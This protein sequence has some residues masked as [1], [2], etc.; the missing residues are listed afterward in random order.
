MILSGTI[1]FAINNNSFFYEA[2][3]GERYK[4]FIIPPYVPHSIQAISRYIMVS[5]CIDK[6]IINMISHT[7]LRADVINLLSRTINLD[8]EKQDEVMQCLN[9]LISYHNNLCAPKTIFIDNLRKQL[10]EFPEQK[11]SVQAMA[12]AAFISKYQFIRNFKKEIGLT[13]HQFQ[14]QNRI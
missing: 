12:Q 8:I 9:E 3:Q 1:I 10:E 5:I 7:Q 13:P 2:T 14:L 4:I 6:K 11:F